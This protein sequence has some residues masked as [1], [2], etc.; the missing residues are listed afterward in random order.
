M[1]GGGRPAVL[2]IKQNDSREEHGAHP[3]LPV[4]FPTESEI[5]SRTT[6]DQRHSTYKTPR[7]ARLDYTETSRSLKVK[8]KT[9][10]NRRSHSVCWGDEGAS[11]SS[12][13]DVPKL[14]LSTSKMKRAIRSGRHGGEWVGCRACRLDEVVGGRGGGSLSL[15]RQP[16]ERRTA[17]VWTCPSPG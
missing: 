15:I 11:S 5:S 17:W 13:S 16:S 4:S 1:G 8:I 2:V 10:A 3:E 7:Q 12:T 9:E 14:S 6:S